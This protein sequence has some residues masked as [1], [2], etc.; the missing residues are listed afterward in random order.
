MGIF[1]RSKPASPPD[2]H[3]PLTVDQAARLRELVRTMLAETGL[4]VV[5]HA[6][7]MEDDSGR[8]LGLW[9]LAA[10]CNE[11]PEREWRDLVG[12]HVAALTDPED[13]DDLDEEVLTTG[14]HLRLVERAGFPDPT[15]HPRSVPVGADLLAVLSI[16]L[17]DTVS[18]P[19][20]DYW[21]G[22]GGLDRWW[23]TGRANLLAVALS[24]DIEHQRLSQED[25]TGAFDVVLGDSFFTASTALVVDHLVRRFDPEADAS[26]GVLVGAPF[27]HQVAW[28]V[29]DGTPDSA[30]ALNNL[31]RFAMLG[32]SDAPGPL[33]PNLFWVRGDEWRQVT[34]IE[35]DQAHVDVDDELAAALGISG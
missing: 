31:F 8:R 17:P 26:R 24:D 4:E 9:N 14:V 16:D 19:R 20:E 27:R 22:R 12:R 11:A 23:A 35:D 10:L 33:S 15:W 6:D 30:A 2:D 34:R 21:D 1:H 18:T 25:G 32:F 13:L 3:L 7:H 5:V 29:L 28:R